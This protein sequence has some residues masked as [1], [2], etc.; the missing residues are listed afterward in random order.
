MPSYF[1]ESGP[2]R[3]TEMYRLARPLIL[4]LVKETTNKY[5]NKFFINTRYKKMQKELLL[6]EKHQQSYD[7]IVENLHRII[8]VGRG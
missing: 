2:A 7:K 1:R 5:L 3:L 8:N 6:G 4:H